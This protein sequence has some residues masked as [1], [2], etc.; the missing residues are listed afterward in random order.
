MNGSTAEGVASAA[1]RV[2]DQLLGRVGGAVLV[3]LLAGALL[4][5]RHNDKA[6]AASIAAMQSQIEALEGQVAAGTMQLTELR[7]ELEQYRRTA[8][9]EFFK[10]RSAK[11]GRAGGATAMGVPTVAPPL[12]LSN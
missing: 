6:Y 7:T 9:D 8:R 2:W 4:M 11:D 1:L 3:G 5:D 12:G 10:R